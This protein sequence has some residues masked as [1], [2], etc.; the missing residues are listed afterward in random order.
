MPRDTFGDLG[1]HGEDGCPLV[2]ATA[3]IPGDDQGHREPHKDGKG[4]QAVAA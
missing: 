4:G 3:V 2:T 1:R